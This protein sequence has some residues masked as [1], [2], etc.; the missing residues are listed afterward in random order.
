MK[1]SFPHEV[2]FVHS[3]G[4]FLSIRQLRSISYRCPI[5]PSS[6]HRLVR[7]T[8]FRPLCPY[9]IILI[10]QGRLRVGRRCIRVNNE[11]SEIMKNSSFHRTVENDENCITSQ[12]AIFNPLLLIQ[13]VLEN[14]RFFN[15]LS[16]NRVFELDYR[17][18]THWLGYNYRWL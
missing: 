10:I 1:C 6:V 17:T 15:K 13:F 2:F 9:S 16:E 7:F 8:N 5:Y 3:V 14:A 12:W 18:S 11:W 4:P